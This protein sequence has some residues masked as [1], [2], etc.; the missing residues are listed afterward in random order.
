MGDMI[1]FA[2]IGLGLA[3]V[4]AIILVAIIAGVL[5][6]AYLGYIP[7]LSDLMGTAKSKDLGVQF[8][9]ADYASGL[10]KI[11]GHIVKNA[12]DL[13]FGCAYISKGSVPVDNTFT[14]AEFTAQI[15][16]FNEKKGPIKNAQVKFNGDGSIEASAMTSL[17]Q[18]NAPVYAK[19]F[20]E[21]VSPRSLKIRLD[22]AKIGPLELV[23]DNLKQAEDA[24]NS[25]IQAFIDQN[26]GLQIES[27]EI[28]DGKV[29]FKGNFPEEIEGDPNSL[30]PDFN[31]P[32]FGG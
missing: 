19:A 26:P 27:L 12:E 8:S 21:S 17:P 29:K 20:I 32:G 16:K 15:N 23:G 11:P 4:G 14:E 7:F 6:L 18:L 3:A 9:P 2:G 5:V 1:K 24:A 30:P 22:S 13:C 25:A 31:I 10:A 28:Q